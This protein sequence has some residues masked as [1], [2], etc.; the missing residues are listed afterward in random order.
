[1]RLRPNPYLAIQSRKT[2]NLALA[3]LNGEEARPFGFATSKIFVNHNGTDWSAT[4]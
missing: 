3:K 2:N 1:M 4:R